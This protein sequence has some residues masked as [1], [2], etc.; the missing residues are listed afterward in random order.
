M[1]HHPLKIGS[2][3]QMNLL[4]KGTECSTRTAKR[5]K[6]GKLKEKVKTLQ[7]LEKWKKVNF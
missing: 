4:K 1:G 2:D 3:L 6:G 5:K 7:K